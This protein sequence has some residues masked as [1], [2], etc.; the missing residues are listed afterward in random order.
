ML[1]QEFGSAF[2]F[3]NED[4]A[5][6]PRLRQAGLEPVGARNANYC[7]VA[8]SQDDRLNLRVA[9]LARDINE[10]VRVTIR[11]FNPVLGHK[12]QEGLELQLHGDFAGCA[13]GGDVRGV[14]RRSIVF[15]CAAVSHARNGGRAR[16][17]AAMSGEIETEEERRSSDFPNATRNSSESPA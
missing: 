12:I 16:R 4:P 8:V 13:R 11:Q 1:A 7:I 14:G 5:D 9:L 15:L 6:P 2:T 3:F 10:H 17:T